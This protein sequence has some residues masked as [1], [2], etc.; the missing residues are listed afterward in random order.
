MYCIA[1]MFD[2]RD[3]TKF[4]MACRSFYWISGRKS[5]LTKFYKKEEDT[6]LI[7]YIELSKSLAKFRSGSNTNL[8]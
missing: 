3:L 5:L 8:N 2:L 4:S 1:N 6:I 7:N